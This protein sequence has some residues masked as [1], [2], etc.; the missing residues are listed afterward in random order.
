VEG[1]QEHEGILGILICLD[2]LQHRLS[3]LQQDQGFLV[4]LLRDEVDRA[5]VQLVDNH[6]HLVLIKVEVFVVVPL[7]RV[8]HALLPVAG[9]SHHLIYHADV[10]HIALFV[11][12]VF[13]GEHLVAD[14]AL[15][16]LLGLVTLSGLQSPTPLKRL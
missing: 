7:E 3:F 8:F 12:F 1:Q 9:L 11:F 15:A 13:S 10:A 14:G 6:G 2:L 4:A 5:L 16:V